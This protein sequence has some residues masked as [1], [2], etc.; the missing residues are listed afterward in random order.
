METDKDFGICFTCGNFR[1]L[2]AFE[3]AQYCDECVG[4]HHKEDRQKGIN[5]VSKRR[6]EELVF[7]LKNRKKYMTEN[8]VCEVK[9][10]EK[11]STEI[12]HKKGRIGA[13]LYDP[14]FFLAVCRKHHNKIENCPKWA[15]EN[16]YSIKRNE[17]T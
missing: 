7:Y 2:N 16:N 11:N 6:K 3:G 4:D 12:H 14:D 5:K 9:G 10:C 17:T 13:L 8:E 15:Y 1:D